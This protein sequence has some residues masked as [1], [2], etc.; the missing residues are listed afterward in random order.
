MKPAEFVDALYLLF[1][2]AP[3]AFRLGI[4]DRLD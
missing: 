1:L 3:P 2:D 4:L